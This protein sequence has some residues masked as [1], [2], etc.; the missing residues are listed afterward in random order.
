MI[1]ILEGI[2]IGLN[3]NILANLYKQRVKQNLKE[4]SIL[5]KM[6]A[7]I[8]PHEKYKELFTDNQLRFTLIDLEG[9]VIYDSKNIS[10]EGLMDNHL[11]RQEIQE[12]LNEQEGFSIRHSDTLDRELAYYAIPIT[13]IYNEK[14]ILRVSSDYSETKKQ[15][16]EFLMVQIAFFLILNYAIHFFYKNYIKRDFYS[17]ITKMK[18]FLQNGRGEKISYLQEEQWLFEFWDVLK[19]WQNNNLKNIERLERERKILS[20]VLSSVDLF[21]GLL[22]ANGTFIVKNNALKYIVDPNRDKYLECVKYLEIISPIKNGLVNKNTFREEIYIQNLKKYFILSMKYLEFTNRYL[23]TI[24]DITST[25]EAVEIQKNFISNVSHELKTPLT[26]IKGYLIALEDAPETMRGRFLNTIKTN[27]ERLENIVLDFLNIS[28]IENSNLVNISQV[29]IDRLKGELET[30]LIEK[31]KKKN[32]VVSYKFNL[33][34]GRDYIKADF[35]KITMILKNLIENGIIYNNSSTPEVDVIVNEKGDRYNI[36]VID[37]GIGIDISEQD[38]IFDRF[39]RVDKARTSN[40][41]GTGLGLAIVKGL[42]EKCGGKVSIESQEGNGT[43]F[44]FYLLK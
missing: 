39:Y 24:K 17:K 35:E 4:D 37:N 5:V 1:L 26:N 33:T 18:D 13:N 27:V 22:D 7:E 43:K 25:R 34:D 12:V 31:I 19:E 6:V 10:K 2:F 36:E 40:L 15:I 32:A 30:I 41:G 8:N 14:Y 11:Q 44:S 16:R 3:S 38:K 29:G 21:I 28:K 9:K 42:I 20:Q 23:I